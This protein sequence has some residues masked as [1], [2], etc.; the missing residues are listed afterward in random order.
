MSNAAIRETEERLAI[1]LNKELQ[2]SLKARRTWHGALAMA[3]ILLAAIVAMMAQWMMTLIAIALGLI[4]ALHCLDANGDLHEVRRRSTKTLVTD[5]S[6]L[7]RPSG[8]S[9]SEVQRTS[10]TS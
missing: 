4:F 7:R 8:D 5:F 10:A 2:A 3:F 9:T 6:V 1:E